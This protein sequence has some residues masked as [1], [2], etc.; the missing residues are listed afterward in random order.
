MRHPLLL[1]ARLRDHEAQAIAAHRPGE[2]MARAAA[3]VARSAR[4]LAR[5][6]PRGSPILTLIGPGNNGGDALLATRLLRDVG[7]A[8][9][10]IGPALVALELDGHIQRHAGGLISRLN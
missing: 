4:G 3:A 8:G 1:T 7:L 9:A 5:A 6:L 2:L 10:Q